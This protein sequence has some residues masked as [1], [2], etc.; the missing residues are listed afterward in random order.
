M[1]AP[2]N[3]GSR[4]PRTFANAHLTRT[5]PPHALPH[6]RASPHPS[7]RGPRAE[8]GLRPP[9]LCL[10]QE[11]QHHYKPTTGHPSRRPARRQ[12]HHLSGHLHH[13]HH[14]PGKIGKVPQKLPK[15]GSN[16][17]STFIRTQNK[18]RTTKVPQNS[19]S[20]FYHIDVCIICLIIRIMILIY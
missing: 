10:L 15:T 6:Q 11:R 20:H 9:A 1:F 5:R 18:V 16:L 3:R 17:K 8:S 2:S 13:P 4:L 7:T 12:H 19:H 14:E